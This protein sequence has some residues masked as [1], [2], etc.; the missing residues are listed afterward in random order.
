MDESVGAI[1]IQTS[2]EILDETVIMISIFAWLQ[3]GFLPL[4]QAS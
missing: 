3:S 1:P 4:F 2:T